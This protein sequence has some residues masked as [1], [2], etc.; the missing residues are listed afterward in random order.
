MTA[1]DREHDHVRPATPDG[2]GRRRAMHA[3]NRAAWD[4]AAER[5][6]GWFAEAVELI[7]SRRLEPVP[8]RGRA[9]R[10]PAR[11]LPP[12]DPP[13]VRRRA[14]H[15]LALEPRRRR[16]RR[17]RLQPA[18]ARPR[19]AADGGDRRAGALDRGGRPGHAR[20]SSTARPTS[21]TRGAAR[22]SGSR[23]STRG[24]RCCAGCSPRPAASCCS[25]ATPPSGCSTSTTTGAGSPPTTTT[26]AGPRRRK[27]WAPEYIDRL[28]IAE[29]DQSWKFARAWTLGE[30][31]TALLGAGLR[32]EAVAEHPSTGGA[33][34]ATSATRSAAGS[35]CRSRSSRPG[36]TGDGARRRASEPQRPAGMCVGAGPHGGLRQPGPARGVRGRL[37][38]PAGPR[39]HPGPARRRRS[40]CWTP[41]SSAASRWR[42]GSTA[43]TRR[44]G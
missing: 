17:R 24:R 20:T 36:A 21:S 9:D 44:G 10:R 13:P 7:R 42:A 3:A 38:R 31:I 39:G 6:E 27:G 18:D 30:I 11:P 23:T 35:R 8:G 37:R 19:G 4:E 43:T 40:S 34:T 28:S 26:S 29:D 25:R 2:A 32:L 1:D 41:S 14:R 33:A 16:G 5:Y 12:G 15:A 22:S